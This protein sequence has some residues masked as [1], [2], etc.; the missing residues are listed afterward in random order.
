MSVEKISAIVLAAGLSR[1]MGCNK[2]LLELNGRPLLEHTLELIDKLGFVQKI[3]ITT[4]KTEEAVQIPSG[5]VTAYNDCAENGLSSSLKLGVGLATCD[6]Y[7]FFLA[8][9]PLLSEATVREIIAEVEPNKII[10]PIVD[11]NP[12]NPVIFP[13][14]LRQELLNV[15]GDKGGRGVIQAH[16]D[17]VKTVRFANSRA[18]MDIDNPDDYAKI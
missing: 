2:L 8:D 16:K 11:D 14:S 15:S 4:R 18:F 9:M 7:M 6:Y 13:K 5:F 3:L 10:L 12:A 1:R 17:C